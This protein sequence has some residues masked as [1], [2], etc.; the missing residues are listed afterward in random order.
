M[1]AL[2]LAKLRTTPEILSLI[3]E[4]DEFKVRGERLVVL[5]PTGCPACRPRASSNAGHNP[6]RPT[7]LESV[8]RVFLWSLQ[9]QKQRL[10]RKV[11]RERILLCDLPELSVAILELARERGRVTMMDAARA[12][13]ASRNT[14]KDHL[15]ALTEQGHLTLHEAGR[16]IWY[17]LN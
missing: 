4:I 6:D 10:A 13:G 2:D 12:T 5:R 11:E 7:G 3:A 9:R 16:G 8:G 15:R 17:G 1:T 14:V